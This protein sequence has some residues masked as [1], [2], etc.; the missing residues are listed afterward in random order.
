G[1]TSIEGDFEENDIINVVGSN[2][3]IIAVGRS[4]YSSSEAKENI[5]AHDLKPLIHYDYLY[6]E[7]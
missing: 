2:N 3:D 4:G 6:M 7:Q 1:V 5:G